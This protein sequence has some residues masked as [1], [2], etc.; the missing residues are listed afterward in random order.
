VHYCHCHDCK[1]E[2]EILQ[3]LLKASCNK[4]IDLS[5]AKANWSRY[6]KQIECSNDTKCHNIIEIGSYIAN[7]LHQYP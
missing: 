4:H 3:T 6:E 7:Y 2:I 5:F 1:S